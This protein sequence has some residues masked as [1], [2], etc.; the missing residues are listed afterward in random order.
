MRVH[1]TVNVVRKNLGTQARVHLIGS[2]LNTG[3]TVINDKLQT[4]VE[5]S[6]KNT[7]D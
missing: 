3:F 2:L 6:I 4:L 5:G 1:L 7:R